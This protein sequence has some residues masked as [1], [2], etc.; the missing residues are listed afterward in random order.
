MHIEPRLEQ[1]TIDFDLNDPEVDKDAV[2][3]KPPMPGIVEDSLFVDSDAE[4]KENLKKFKI[5]LTSKRSGKKIDVNI[6]FIR[7]YNKLKKPQVF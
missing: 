3:Q 5:R 1:K 7:S 2:I 4:H 6:K